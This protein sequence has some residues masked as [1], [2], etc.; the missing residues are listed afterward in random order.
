MAWNP[1]AKVI[2]SAAEPCAHAQSALLLPSVPKGLCNQRLRWV[3]DLLA[4]QVARAAVVLPDV[5]YSRRG[6]HFHASCF[7]EYSGDVAFGAVFDVNETSRLLAEAG[8]CVLSAAAAAARFPATLGVLPRDALALPTSTSELFAVQEELASRVAGARWLLAANATCCTLVIPSTAPSASFWRRINAAFKPTPSLRSG[9]EAV[10]RLFQRA[11]AAEGA[12][13][14]ALHWRGQSDMQLSSHKLNVT[15]YALETA[16]ALLRVRGR[17]LGCSNGSACGEPAPPLSVLALGGFTAPQ[18]EELRRTLS[19]ALAMRWR[20]EGGGPADGGSM[21]GDTGGGDAGGGRGS[22]GGGGGIAIGSAGL[23]VHSKESLQPGMDFGKAFGGNDDAVGMIDLEVARITP[24]FVGSP[25]SSL[26]VVAAALRHGAERRN[27]H[28]SESVTEMVLADVGDRLGAIF[29]LQAP[30]LRGGEGSVAAADPC[31]ALQELF[32]FERPEWS[33][34]KRGPPQSHLFSP[35]PRRPHTQCDSLIGGAMH[36]LPPV[37]APSRLS[38]NCTH[39]VVTAVYNDYDRLPYYTQ[40]FQR[41]LERQEAERGA[42]TCWFAFTDTA[43]IRALLPPSAVKTAEAAVRQGPWIRYGMWH[44]VVLPD[45]V[46]FSSDDAAHRSIRSRLPKM[47]PHCVLAHAGKMLYID[48][49]LKVVR[50]ESFWLMIEHETSLSNPAWVAPMHPNRHTV[51]DELVCL[52]L[53]GMVT[54]RAFEQLKTYHALGFPSNR[55]AAAGGP[56]LAEGNWHARD[57]RALDS[58]L[59]GNAWAAEYLQWREHSLRDQLS[60]NFIVWRLGLLPGRRA[61]RPH[62]DPPTGRGQLGDGTEGCAD[63]TCEYRPGGAPVGGASGDARGILWHMPTPVR[64]EE[65]RRQK[66]T[67]NEERQ[68]RLTWAC[69][70][71]WRCHLTRYPDLRETAAAQRLLARASL[72]P[73][74]CACESGIELQVLQHLTPL[75]RTTETTFLR[76]AFGGKLKENKLSGLLSSHRW[77]NYASFALDN[78]AT[79][80]QLQK[81]LGGVGR[82]TAADIGARNVSLPA[83]RQQLNVAGRQPRRR[84]GIGLG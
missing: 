12:V 62:G 57:L 40:T 84:R 34:A 7:K 72:R 18:L 30:Y 47:M 4:A 39:A 10:L 52:Y 54:Q 73:G 49:K 51:R 8:L 56:G 25:F 1:A 43:S 13:A 6:C 74:G 53:A 38:F 36:V 44:L 42:R 14:V 33:C 76:R 27:G 68:L 2:L 20:N 79:F 60:F 81:Q 37:D 5:L 11:A 32:D 58:T 61:A 9:A 17:L 77:C 15:A 71:T 3:Q 83:R 26:S 59:I 66:P 67:R 75:P 70:R 21:A 48:A 65:V 41:R 80:V 50:P 46:R 45:T 22:A 55:L 23:Q 16:A 29:A 19:W 82:V 24:V 78:L 28:N 63:R 69:A 64:R 31:A 35:V